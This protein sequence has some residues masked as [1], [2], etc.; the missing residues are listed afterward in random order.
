MTRQVA[1][2]TTE[3]K[4]EK[5]AFHSVKGDGTK[6]V[7]HK[8][9]DRLDRLEEMLASYLSQ[10]LSQGFIKTQHCLSYPTNNTICFSNQS[11]Q[12]ISFRMS[13]VG[14][15][16]EIIRGNMPNL[17]LSYENKCFSIDHCTKIAPKNNEK[18]ILDSGATDHMTGN[19]NLLRSFR[20]LENDQYFTVANDEKIKIKGWGMISILNKNFL[21]DVFYIENCT[22]NLLSISKLTKELNCQIIFDQDNVIFQDQITKEKI[23]EGFL[24]NGLYFLDSNKRILNT[25][26]DEDLSNLLHK[27]VGHPSDKILKIMFN[28]SKDFCNK[29]DVCKFAK[30]TKLP[31]N[32]STS[33]S[34]EVFELIH[35]DVWGPAPVDSYNG[36]K[37][38]VIFIDDFSRATWLYL[39]KNKNEVFSHFQNFVNLIETQ[40]DKKIKILRTDNGT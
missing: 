10:K 30:Q 19:R 8:T 21:Q 23:G 12:P 39:M 20:T 29:C 27:R 24:E 22:V 31:F 11:N 3:P 4:D 36:Y 32:N 28:F 33:K 5:K 35:S 25:K 6:G 14:S 1:M 2:G 37:Y 40:Y 15:G 9:S 13:N 26:R 7:N 34:N 18:W 17:K 16:P 38:Y